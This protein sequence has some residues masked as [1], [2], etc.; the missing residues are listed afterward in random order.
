[1]KVYITMERDA[2]SCSNDKVF[3][4]EL[5]AKDRDCFLLKRKERD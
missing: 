3:D 5:K 1:M 2:E 4:T